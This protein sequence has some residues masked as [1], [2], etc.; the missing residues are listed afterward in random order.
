MMKLLLPIQ[1]MVVTLE[2]TMCTLNQRYVDTL[3]LGVAMT[4]QNKGYSECLTT[5]QIKFYWIPD[6]CSA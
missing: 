5:K 6:Y 3:L 2:N 1:G 4:F